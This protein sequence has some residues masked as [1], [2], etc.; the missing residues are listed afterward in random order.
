MVGQTLAVKNSDATMHNVMASPSENSPFNF[1]MPAKDQ[2][3]NRVF[4]EPEFK[5]KVRCF[6]HPWMI[7]YVH[8]LENPYFAVT[9]IDGKFSIKGLPPGE[10]SY[11]AARELG[12]EGDAGDGDGEDRGGADG[13]GGFCL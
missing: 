1:G 11:G 7:G 3:I 13:G 12:P 4:K 10:Y 9:G 8:V 5:M 2:I 6:M